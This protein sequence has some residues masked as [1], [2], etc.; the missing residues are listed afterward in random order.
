MWL[1]PY[2]NQNIQCV[3]GK[4]MTWYGIMGQWPLEYETYFIDGTEQI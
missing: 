3:I 2:K 4:K 1:S